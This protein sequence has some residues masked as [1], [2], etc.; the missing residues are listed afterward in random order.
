MN[1]CR[2]CGTALTNT[3][4][5]VFSCEKGHVLFADNAPSTA[6]FFVRDDGKVLLARRAVDPRKGMLDA[7]GGF[8]QLNEAAE[9]AAIREINEETGLNPDQYDE[10]KLLGTAIGHY[11]YEGERVPVLTIIFWAHLHPGVELQANDDV[12]EI[13]AYNINDINPDELHDN[14]IRSGLLKLR[15]AMQKDTP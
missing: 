7:I 5:N 8:V 15:A 6:V 2:R 4:D 14:D 11:P 12:A 1:F 13:I 3:Q 10:L 9:E